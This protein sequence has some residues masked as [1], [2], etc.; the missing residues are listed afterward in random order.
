MDT[1]P[2]DTS[3]QAEY[4]D[5]FILD[6]TEHDDISPYTGIHNIFNDILEKRPEAE[7]GRLVRFSVF[8][9]NQRHDVDFTGLPANARPIRF[10]HGFVTL[11]QS[12]VEVRGWSGIQ[13]G[14]QYNDAN[15]RN[16]Q[17]VIDL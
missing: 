14:Y 7:H 17:E 16:V 1:L 13:F 10:R 3:V 4:A 12:G 5:G 2:L 6:E 9:N 8:Y 15:G 11:D